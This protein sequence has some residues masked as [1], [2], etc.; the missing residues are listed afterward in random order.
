M[1]PLQV[2]SRMSVGPPA[3]APPHF[4][5]VTTDYRLLPAF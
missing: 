3:Q 2:P 5:F 1:V 4:F